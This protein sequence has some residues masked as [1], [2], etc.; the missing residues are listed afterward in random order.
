MKY[1]EF[2]KEQAD[3]FYEKYCK[4]IW[5]YSHCKFYFNGM[6]SMPQGDETEEEMAYENCSES[7]KEVC[8]KEHYEE[9]INTECDEAE[10]EYFNNLLEEHNVNEIFMTK[11]EQIEL[12][13]KENQ[14]L[15]E[16]LAKYE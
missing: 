1:K 11:D 4:N 6:C 13:K 3:A 7:F 14:K 10:E 5:C 12:L 8:T 15:K 9:L 16:R 2:T